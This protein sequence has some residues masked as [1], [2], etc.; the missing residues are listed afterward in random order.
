MSDLPDL[1]HELELSFSEASLTREEKFT[2]IQ[3]FLRQTILGDQPDLIQGYTP[4]ELASRLRKSFA[5]LTAEQHAALVAAAKKLKA[6]RLAE[7][8]ARLE[9]PTP[10][11]EQWNA[12]SAR[13]GGD[14]FQN[15]A[16]LETLR[17]V[18]RD[19]GLAVSWERFCDRV[20]N[21]IAHSK[22]N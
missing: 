10:T 17:S 7:T 16:K 1:L 6:T 14:L 12:L 5:S 15:A 20:I 21:R 8:G 11:I 13:V 18:D 22:E 2:E 19:L 9:I 4:E 3:R